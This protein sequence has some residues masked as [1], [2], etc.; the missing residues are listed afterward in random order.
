MTLLATYHG[1]KENDLKLVENN[2]PVPL[3]Q[4]AEIHPGVQFVLAFSPGHALSIRDGQGFSRFDY[5]VSGLNSWQWDQQ[6]A[7][8]DDLSLVTLDGPELLHVSNPETLLAT[9]QAYQPN[10][11][12]TQPNLEASQSGNTSCRR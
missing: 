1:L 10:L 5:L 8:V 2:L 6:A 3:S 9:L 12:N 11:R 7:G 4:F